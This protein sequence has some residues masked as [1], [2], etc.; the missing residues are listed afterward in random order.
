MTKNQGKIL[1]MET[2]GTIGINSCVFF[3]FEKKLL[4][5]LV[6]LRYFSIVRPACA[7]TEVYTRL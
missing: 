3:G 4:W 1:P 5:F 6:D 2:T 7:L